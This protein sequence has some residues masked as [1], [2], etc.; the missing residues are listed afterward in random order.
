MA[1]YKLKSHRGLA[2]RIKYSATGKVIRRKAGKTHKLEVK[3]GKRR[4]NLRKATVAN[5]ADTR[6]CKLLV[7]VR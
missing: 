6:K 7:P 2:K 3:S 1:K 4:R 5:R